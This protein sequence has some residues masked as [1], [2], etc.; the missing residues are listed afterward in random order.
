MAGRG[1]QKSDKAE[2]MDDAK[3]R[4]QVAGDTIHFFQHGSFLLWVIWVFSNLVLFRSTGGISNFFTS[5]FQVY[6]APVQ[7]RV[8]TAWR[9]AQPAIELP[10]GARQRAGLSL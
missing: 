6:L 9:Q 4:V 1:G 7:T 2:L 5:R 10:K 3:N 8:T